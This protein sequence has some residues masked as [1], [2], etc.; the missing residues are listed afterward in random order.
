MSER[1]PDFAFVVDGKESFKSR[2]Q[3]LIGTRS[4]RAAAK[5]WGVPVSTINNYLQKNTLSVAW[6]SLEAGEQEQLAKLLARKGA[7]V[8]VTLL[9]DN[10][11]RLLQLQGIKRQAAIKL[12]D[13]PESRVREILAEIESSA[14]GATITEH[15]ASA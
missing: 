12:Q 2:L 15:S 10:T 1:S 11:L 5:D 6:A 8:L 14:G 4:V 3:H 13:M 7:E 9:D